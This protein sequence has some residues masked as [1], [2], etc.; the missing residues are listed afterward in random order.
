MHY[1]IILTEKCNL[2]C[3]YCYEK[4]LQDFDNNLDKK[5]EFDFSEP[6]DFEL[7]VGKLKKFLLKDSEPV[8]V[9]YGGEPLLKIDLIKKIIDSL[10]E[11]RVKFRMQT[12]G[13]FL[14][15][16]PV[17]YL[18][19][20]G[21]ILVSIDGG[22]KVTDK[23]RGNGVYEK[24]IS[25][26]ILARNRGY[27][28]EFVARMT[29]SQEDPDVYKRVKHLVKLID[30]GVFDSVHWQLDVGFYSNDFNLEKVSKFFKK[31]NKS[32]LK[33][34]RW[35]F[36]Q[37]KKGRVYRIY[38]YVGIAKPIILGNDSCGLRCGSGH[39]GYTITTSGK[40]VH[41]PIMNSI[42]TFE[43]GDLGS[44]PDKLKKFSCVYGCGDCEVY[45]LCGGRCMYW[46]QAKLWPK[47]GNDL[48]C[49]S[50][51]KYIREIQKNM[52]VIYKL[53]LKKKIRVEDFLY[54]DYFGP[55]IIP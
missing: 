14:D 42:K 9:F 53:I 40:I 8:L 20:I 27:T 49:D 34:I 21:K 3:K 12:N 36:S 48:I 43:A 51:K 33:L 15:K 47:E 7:D 38:P 54:E 39:A 41:C 50:I 6:E 18:E 22:C 37:I 2:R 35:W 46:R 29:V 4:S 32:N 26:L 44:E 17:E 30:S 5:F 55:E 11:T 23:Y 1:H 31:Y 45:G 19:K 16:L 10:S 52:V 24:V 13:I 28:G 25:N